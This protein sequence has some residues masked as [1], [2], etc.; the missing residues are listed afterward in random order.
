MLGF[1]DLERLILQ[2]K[3]INCLNPTGFHKITYYEWGNASAP[4]TIVCAH[5]LTRNGR[6]FDFLAQKLSEYGKYRVVCVDLAGRGASAKFSNPH[7]Y[8]QIQYAADLTNLIAR[9]DVES[10]IWIGTSLG[11]GLGMYLAAQANTPLKALILNDVGPLISKIGIKRIMKY[12]EHA[13]KFRSIDEV[14]TFLRNV[15]KTNEQIS[16]L[17]WRNLAETSVWLTADNQYVL[18]YDPHITNAIHKWWIPDINLWNL[19]IQIHC[20]VLAIRGANSDILLSET[21]MQM[22]ITGPRATVVE[23]ADCGHAPMLMTKDQI[24]II[25]KWLENIFH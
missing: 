18:A 23:I 15:Y 14:E 8:N 1:K 11:G 16:D 6:D 2:K 22:Q 12:T 5:G 10:V 4:H 17:Q 13:N 21:A 9:L 20:P 24:D 3:H 19:W 25:Q 7:L